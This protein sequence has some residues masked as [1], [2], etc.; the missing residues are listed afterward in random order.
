MISVLLFGTYSHAL[1][2]C[3][4]VYLCIQGLDGRLSHLSLSLSKKGWR[5]KKMKKTKLSRGQK[6]E[7]LFRELKAPKW[8]GKAKTFP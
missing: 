2:T 3:R 1:S 4:Y 8:K 6:K 5:F 7:K